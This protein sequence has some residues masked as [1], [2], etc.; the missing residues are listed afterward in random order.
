MV[1]II[2]EDLCSIRGAVELAY[3]SSCTRERLNKWVVWACRQRKTHVASWAIRAT[4]K[5]LLAGELKV[6]E[7]HKVDMKKDSCVGKRRCFPG[8]ENKNV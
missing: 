1:L 3:E 7:W 4:A 8:Q 5:M 6:G 2:L